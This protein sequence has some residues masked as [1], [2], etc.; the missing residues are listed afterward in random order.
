MDAIG[1]S[2]GSVTNN[3]SNSGVSSMLTMMLQGL[4]FSTVI[5]LVTMLLTKLVGSVGGS[6]PLKWWHWIRNRKLSKLT[7]S[8]DLVDGYFQ[9]G[10]VYNETLINAVLFFIN[11][12]RL[13]VKYA[14]VTLSKINHLSSD[15]LNSERSR[16]FNL[17]PID[18]VRFGDITIVYSQT[19]PES[20]ANALPSLSKKLYVA[21]ETKTIYEL[22]QFVDTCRMDYI[23]D[24]LKHEAK[25]YYYTPRN[26]SDKSPITFTKYPFKSCKS[27]STIFFPEKQRVE[28]TCIPR[29]KAIEK[30]GVFI[31][32]YPRVR[33]NVHDQSV[34]CANGLS[35]RFDQTVQC[36]ERSRFNGCVAQCQ[37]FIWFSY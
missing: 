13:I 34:G 14:D 12:H 11:K 22:Q 20:K 6:Y 23:Q 27:F 30:I 10:Q 7:I 18:T 1:A 2:N 15:T 16:V 29:A 3:T 32:G 17:H 31:I 8:C 25:Q 5:P 35:Y 33:Q 28:I 19:T 36:H 21:S 4:L 24:Q 9:H 26:R 37:H